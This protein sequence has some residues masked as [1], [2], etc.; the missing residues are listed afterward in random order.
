MKICILQPSYIP[1]K[2]YFHQIALADVFVFLDTVQYDKRGWRNRN[3][4]KTH[5]GPRWLTIPVH[6]HGTHDGLLIRDVKVQSS[7]WARAHLDTIRLNYKKAPAFSVEFPALENLLLETAQ[8]ESSISRIAG[9]TTRAIAQRLGISK[10][11]L[12]YASELPSDTASL[13]PSQRLLSIVQSLGGTSYL[14]GPNAQDY[15]DTA[16]FSQANVSVEW[17]QYDYPEA[18]QLYPPFTH[19]VSIVDLLLM[20]GAEQTGQWIWPSKAGFSAVG[21][22]SNSR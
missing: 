3:Q 4:I 21:I 13:E 9:E 1:W 18:P 6:A 12:M 16:L 11:R 20:V 8:Q 5:Q 15:L 22:P 19:Q 14:S 17:M 10:T 2:G 7:D